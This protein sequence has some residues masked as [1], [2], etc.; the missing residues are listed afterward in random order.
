MTPGGEE[1]VLIGRVVGV[2][3]LRGDVKVAASAFS[4]V[5]GQRVVARAAGKGDRSLVVRSVRP[6]TGH[7]RVAFEDVDDANAADELRGAALLVASADLPPL[8][9][10]AYRE[11]ELVGMR[12]V[13]EKLGDVGAVVGIAQY[14]S[15]DMLVVGAKRVLIPMLAAYGLRVDRVTRTITTALP[16]GF[17]ELL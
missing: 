14:P 4:L 13:D 11:A 9:A 1:L 2:F 5:A 15:A 8:P 10:D 7:V 17:E 3:G 16:D 12:V 6:A